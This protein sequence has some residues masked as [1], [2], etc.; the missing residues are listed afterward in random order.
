MF[1]FA[2][3]NGHRLRYRLRGQGPLVVFGHGLMGKIEQVMPEGVD[4]E[5]VFEQVRLLTYDA[6]GH[7]HSHGPEDPEQYTWET[8]GRDMPALIAHAGEESAIV[9]GASMGAATALW[10]AV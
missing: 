7:G 1:D 2:E 4:L 10:M 5:G 6:R 9:G 8:L 3:I